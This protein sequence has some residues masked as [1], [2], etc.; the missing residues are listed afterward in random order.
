MFATAW[1]ETRRQALLAP[2]TD[3]RDRLAVG[4]FRIRTADLER[5]SL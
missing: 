4:V 1:D 3:D 2:L 5:I